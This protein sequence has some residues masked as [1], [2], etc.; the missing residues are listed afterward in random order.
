[1]DKGNQ[2]N[3]SRND[4]DSVSPGVDSIGTARRFALLDGQDVPMESLI[5][6][7]SETQLMATFP[8]LR[9]ICPLFPY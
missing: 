3:T 4:K 2:D 8:C 9:H 7:Y 6:R 1:M 5:A